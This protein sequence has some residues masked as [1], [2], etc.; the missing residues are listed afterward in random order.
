MLNDFLLIFARLMY[1]CR[2]IWWQRVVVVE[3]SLQISV[4]AAASPYGGTG[5]ARCRSV[6]CN[7][8]YPDDTCVLHALA[9]AVYLYV[10]T[11]HQKWDIIYF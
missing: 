11:L 10:C 7:T 4:C 8:P 6:V 2:C 5:I 1:R 3:A 9:I